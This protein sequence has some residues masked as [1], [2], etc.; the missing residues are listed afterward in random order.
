MVSTWFIPAF[1][2]S[3]L[4]SPRGRTGADGRTLCACCNEKNSRNVLRA[5]REDNGP[6]ARDTE[7]QL[8]VDTRRDRCA[9]LRTAPAYSAMFTGDHEGGEQ[10]IRA[11]ARRQEPI[12]LEDRKRS[13]SALRTEERSQSGPRADF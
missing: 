9:Q 12:R 6:R 1:T 2:N 10:P 13:K 5:L 11:K 4:G 3:R 7:T 8:R